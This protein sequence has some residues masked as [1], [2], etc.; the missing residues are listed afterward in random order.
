MSIVVFHC[1]GSGGLVWASGDWAKKAAFSAQAFLLAPCLSHFHIL[2]SGLRPR[3]AR[4]RD[5]WFPLEHELHVPWRW[6]SQP[7]HMLAQTL[8]P[9]APLPQIVISPHGMAS[10]KALFCLSPVAIAIQERCVFPILRNRNICVQ[11]WKSLSGSPFT[12]LIT[13]LW[14]VESPEKFKGKRPL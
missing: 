1:S 7:L 2:T 8:Q 14:H 11:L 6:N 9:P 13:S 5:W 4:P 12:I 3:G 10:C